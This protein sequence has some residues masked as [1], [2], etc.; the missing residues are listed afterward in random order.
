M[1]SGMDCQGCS[2]GLSG[3]GSLGVT[4]S[5]LQAGV[6][7]L[8]NFV[9]QAKQLWHDLED[10]LGIG[11][12]RREADVVVPVQNEVVSRIITPVSAYLTSINNGTITPT[13][14]DLRVWYAQVL[15]AENSW[16]H[17]LH[18][19]QWIDGR[20]AD[21]AESTLLPY[22]TNAKRDLQKYES[23][24]CGT[25]G[26]VFGGMDTTTLISIGLAAIVILPKLF[27]RG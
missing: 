8:K 15:D 11:A 20:A 3:L 1:D 21:Q 4:S 24:Y 19:T 6:S 16:L 2:H 22:W 27:K 14:T 25:F 17:F 12:G 9:T 26:G 13:C 5:E 18:D 10:A 7:A 23:Q